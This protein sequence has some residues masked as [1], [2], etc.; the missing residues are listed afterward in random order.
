MTTFV[1][2]ENFKDT[3][4]QYKGIVFYNRDNNLIQE[5]SATL[6]RKDLYKAFEVKRKTIEITNDISGIHQ[7]EIFFHKNPIYNTTT[8]TFSVDFATFIED[9]EHDTFALYSNM[10]LP[11]MVG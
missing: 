3:E 9:W 11:Q 5:A 8:N 1:F 10:S 2:G 7:V 4:I 6:K